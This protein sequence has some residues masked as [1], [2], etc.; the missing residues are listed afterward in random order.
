MLKEYKLTE[1]KKPG[2]NLDALQQARALDISRQA[3]PRLC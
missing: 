2:F 3:R 1:P